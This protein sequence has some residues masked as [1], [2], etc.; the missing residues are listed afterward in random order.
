MN[1]SDTNSFY[2]YDGLG[3][4][5]A[6]SDVNSVIVERY[7]YDVFGEPNRVSVV[8]NPY[9]FTG[10]RYESE[11]DLYYYRAR[12][13]KPE[14]GRFLQ[15]DPISYAGG[16]N[17]Y[18]YC[19]NDPINWIDPY[20]ET[21]YNPFDWARG[22]G[23]GAKKTWRW[24][25]RKWDAIGIPDWWKDWWGNPYNWGRWAWEV[26][27]PAPVKLPFDVADGGYSFCSI[28]KD[29]R[30][31]NKGSKDVFDNEDIYPWKWGESD[32]KD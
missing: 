32:K 2:H 3:S 10:R 23:R 31:H 18:T 21:W 6:L 14:I 24:T 26:F 5:A 11:T 30:R 22:I 7:S 19:N 25:K 15:T 4:V 27:A 1:R 9:M 29:R 8:H 16:L 20:G 17:L 28:E 13:H 12:Y